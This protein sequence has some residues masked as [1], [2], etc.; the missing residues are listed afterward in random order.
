MLF[1]K[2]IDEDQEH[3]LGF[4]HTE[5]P[6]HLHADDGIAQQCMAR[7]GMGRSGALSG[8]H[9]CELDRPGRGVPCA[10]S[11]QS[12]GQLYEP[13]VA[14][15]GDHSGADGVGGRAEGGAICVGGLGERTAVGR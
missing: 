4:G 1:A 15:A 7:V 12:G 10:I 9:Q 2:L 5:D 3:D 13:H 14:R 6:A 11:G 8:D